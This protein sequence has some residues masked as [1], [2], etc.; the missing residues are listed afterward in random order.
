MYLITS[1]SPTPMGV[2][3]DIQNT[4]SLSKTRNSETVW[5][6]WSSPYSH[7]TAWIPTAYVLKVLFYVTDFMQVSH[8]FSL[9][10]GFNSWELC[11]EL[12]WR[13]S[14]LHYSPAPP[15]CPE[16]QREQV[17]P[18]NHSSWSHFLSLILG[19]KW[20]AWASLFRRIVSHLWLPLL[21]LGPALDC[22]IIGMCLI[23][24]STRQK[25]PDVHCEFLSEPRQSSGIFRKN[26]LNWGSSCSKES[27][28]TPYL[29]C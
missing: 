18:H 27:E 14:W 23:L 13:D 24:S 15:A 11:I 7:K 10:R 26:K 29:E 5:G 6:L 2:F 22:P 8:H 9:E 19:V 1:T 20:Q 16:S 3:Q 4:Q 12:K 28:R 25:P 21:A 17:L